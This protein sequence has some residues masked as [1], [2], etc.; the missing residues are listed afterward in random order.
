VRVFVIV[1]AVLSGGLMTF[2][3]AA[4]ELLA[5]A[6]IILVAAAWINGVCGKEGF[7]SKFWQ[8]VLLLIFLPVFTCII[9]SKIGIILL[10]LI[11]VL[12]AVAAYM[13]VR[14]RFRTDV[15]LKGRERRP[16][17]PRISSNREEFE[18][19]DSANDSENE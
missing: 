13:E 17:F 9:L 11:I 19:E 6:A 12:A 14:D 15:P 7:N 1:I 2:R 10:I 16:I 3:I 18:H 5:S 4:G 8:N